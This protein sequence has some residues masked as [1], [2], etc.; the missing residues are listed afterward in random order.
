[1]QQCTCGKGYR[2]HTCDDAY[3][4]ND[5]GCSGHGECDFELE[6]CKCS[7]G[8]SG[9]FCFEPSCGPA[10]DCS[11]HGI[12]VQDGSKFKCDCMDGFEASDCHIRSVPVVPIIKNKKEKE[13][14]IVK[15]SKEQAEKA[16]DRIIENGGTKEEAELAAK[17]VEQEV[18]AAAG[19]PP[20][21]EPSS[22]I[23]LSVP[24][25]LRG[26]PGDQKGVMTDIFQGMFKDDAI[27]DN[28]SKSPMYELASAV[29]KVALDVCKNSQSSNDA[30]CGPRLSIPLQY[31]VSNMAHEWCVRTPDG[32]CDVHTVKVDR[33][34]SIVE[35]LKSAEALLESDM[36]SFDQVKAAILSRKLYDALGVSPTRGNKA[37]VDATMA[38]TEHYAERF[39][40]S[41]TLMEHAATLMIELAELDAPKDI[42]SNDSTKDTTS[43]RTLILSK[44]EIATHAL[45]QSDGKI[46][47]AR[48]L[49]EQ[50]L[51]MHGVQGLSDFIYKQDILVHLSKATMSLADI[52]KGKPVK[53][54]VMKSFMCIAKALL[55]LSKASANI[56]KRT[57]TI[58]DID[59]A[60]E[61]LHKM[62]MKQ[63]GAQTG[64]LVSEKLI[65]LCLADEL[66]KPDG[67]MAEALE[68][69][70]PIAA[71]KK[72]EKKG[73]VVT[74]EKLKK[75]E[76]AFAGHSINAVD[77]AIATADGK[78]AKNCSNHGT[79]DVATQTCTCEGSYLGYDCSLNGHAIFSYKGEIANSNTAKFCLVCCSNHA[80]DLCNQHYTQ[81]DRRVYDSCYTEEVKNCN[82][83]CRSEI[84]ESIGPNRQQLSC[85]ATA[86]RVVNKITQDPKHSSTLS[87]TKKILGTAFDQ[88]DHKENGEAVLNRFLS[89]Q[90]AKLQ[91]VD[92]L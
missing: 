34:R 91:S 75:L 17:A 80:Y 73:I 36:S 29:N 81:K 26:S 18:T 77:H 31:A 16:Y 40:S 79:C 27:P 37:V 66:D 42:I 55:S 20:V 56:Q 62:A 49:L 85:A 48:G 52:S 11:G 25:V 35:D 88:D 89:K 4:G 61:G 82:T 41:V 71:T 14:A 70:T 30:A 90:A 13:K 1:L 12:C 2:G 53:K 59:I 19:E 44:C 38:I 21:Q 78:C 65:S 9:E 6:T 8:W 43:S 74:P 7:A 3:C 28:G 45:L 50:A 92:H 32:K 72:L 57:P 46:S 86:D 58:D 67:V 76:V 63:S 83:M 84:D 69:V 51:V 15:A 24:L 33:I 60:V 47:A 39:S 54:E 87:D 68:V 10:G 22:S 23:S 5:A 64:P